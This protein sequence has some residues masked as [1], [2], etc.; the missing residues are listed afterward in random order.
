[1]FYAACGLVLSL[2]MNVTSFTSVKLSDSVLLPALTYAI[3]P[4]FFAVI[5]ISIS[6]KKRKMPR[7]ADHEINYW[8]FV[9]A[10]CPMLMKY[11]FL[12]LFRLCMGG[13]RGSRHVN[14]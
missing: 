4:A 14:A 9:L 11:I 5:L 12:G 2:V 7:R 1:M 3:F 10:G 13:R 6:E 8:E